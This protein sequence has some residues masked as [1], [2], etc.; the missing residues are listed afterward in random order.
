[1]VSVWTIKSCQLNLRMNQF[2]SFDILYAHNNF[3]AISF[4]FFPN[5]LYLKNEILCQ[6]N[7]IL[8]IMENLKI[9]VNL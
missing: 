2:N 7:F 9:E 4:L 5:Y 8:F 3:V 1:M 6:V